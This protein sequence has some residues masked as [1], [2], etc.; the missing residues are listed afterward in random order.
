MATGHDIAMGLR[1]AYWAMHRQV[2]AC[3]SGRGVTADQFVLLSLL[4]EEDGITQQQLVQRAS[5]DANTVRAMLV[6]LEKR[7]LVARERHPTDGRARSVTLTRKGRHILDK[8]WGATEPLRT[9]LLASF[10]PE[11]ADRVAES[12]ARISEVM[13]QMDRCTRAT[14]KASDATGR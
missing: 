11:E 7:G 1:A 3:C 5:S 6:L 9:G 10:R 13:A 4:G 8:I 2:D 12:L 14:A